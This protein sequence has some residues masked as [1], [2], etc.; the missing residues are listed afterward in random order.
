MSLVDEVVTE[1]RCPLGPRRLF[2]I[3][4]Q[5]GE[6]P[7]YIQPENWIEFSCYDCRRSMSERGQRVK[8]VLHRYD[9]AGEFMGTRV[10]EDLGG[11][12]GLAR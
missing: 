7:S 4:R 6:R 8:R 10:V 1:M 3:M 2:G 11:R 12:V 9:L 5:H